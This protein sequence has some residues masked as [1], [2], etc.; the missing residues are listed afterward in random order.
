MESFFQRCKRFCLSFLWGGIDRQEWN[1]RGTPLGLDEI[2]KGSLRKEGVWI[3]GKAGD[4]MSIIEKSEEKKQP[5]AEVIYRGLKIPGIPAEIIKA[6]I[7]ENP[8][9]VCQAGSTAQGTY[10]SPENPNGTDDID[11]HAV[12][13]APLWQHF[14]YREVFPKARHVLIN[15]WDCTQVELRKFVKLLAEG[16]PNMLVDL[17]LP[18]DRYIYVSPTFELLKK[19]RGLFL[20]RK[21]IKSFGGRAM[22]M[23]EEMTNLPQGGTQVGKRQQL[24]HKFGYDTRLAASGLR[25]LQ[26][27]I[28][29]LSLGTL[30][31]DR[32]VA[33]DNEIY[34]SIKLGE[35]AL[36]DVISMGK[37]LNKE[38]D[39]AARSTI[40]PPE[41]DVPAVNALLTE[42][43]SQELSSEVVRVAFAGKKGD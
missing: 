22:E 37:N 32:S 33:E 30:I 7:P 8:W 16:H 27:G 26:M 4:P 40:L 12:Y 19:S 10:I 18:D 17:F 23:F 35:W 29:A 31:P 42:I 6:M 5:P 9:M 41:E 39:D 3:H 28:E 13:I 24:F 36:H 43:L 15:S 25:T 2:S 14:G 21:I 38:F 34:L 20:T 1:P 11:F